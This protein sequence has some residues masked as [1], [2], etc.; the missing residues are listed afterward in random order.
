[1]HDWTFPCWHVPSHLIEE[2]VTRS[3]PWHTNTHTCSDSHRQVT[4]Q[5]WANCWYSSGWNCSI[6]CPDCFVLTVFSFQTN[7]LSLI[8]I[9]Q[10]LVWAQ[11]QLGQLLPLR[12]V[13]CVCHL[14]Q[15]APQTH[16]KYKVFFSHMVYANFTGHL[17]GPSTGMSMSTPT[18]RLSHGA[19]THIHPQQ[20]SALTHTRETP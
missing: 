7:N 3:S 5:T 1:M 14:R 6:T 19:T 16:L 18:L 13:R 11:V 17:H 20:A 4:V 10:E 2:S 12:S 15:L 9:G 8:I